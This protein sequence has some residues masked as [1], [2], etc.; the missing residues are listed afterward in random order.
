MR[1]RHQ[2]IQQLG[3]NFSGVAYDFH[4]SK[5][6]GKLLNFKLYNFLR[7]A[8]YFERIEQLDIFLLSINDIDFKLHICQH[9][10]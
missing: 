6:R 2:Y 9:C 3:I 5:Y 7:K 10:F 1:V 4:R 8:L